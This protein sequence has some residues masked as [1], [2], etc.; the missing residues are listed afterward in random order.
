MNKKEL[1]KINELNQKYYKSIIA[2][3]PGHVYWKDEN[4]RFLGCNLN[5]AKD[6]GF[7]SCDD[8]VG[9]TDFDMPWAKDAEILQK[10]DAK[11]I[12]SK[13]AS[14]IEEVCELPD[15][16]KKIY[17]SHKLPL[18]DENNQ[19]SGVL[20]ISLDISDRKGI[21][22]KL[23]ASYQ[24]LSFIATA[25]NNVVR[26][27]IQSISL[28]IEMFKDNRIAADEA[29]EIIESATSNLLPT[30]SYASDYAALE[31]GRLEVYQSKI[32]LANLLS[33]LAEDIYNSH[34]IEVYFNFNQPNN[35]VITTDTEKLI[36]VL[37]TLVTININTNEDQKLIEIN[38]PK[39]KVSIQIKCNTDN[40]TKQIIEAVSKGSID[41]NAPTTETVLRLIYCKKLLN[42]LGIEFEFSDRKTETFLE[43]RIPSNETQTDA[44]LSKNITIIDH[45]SSRSKALAS[46]DPVHIHTKTSISS[47]NKNELEIT[48]FMDAGIAREALT[49]NK[50]LN[51]STSCYLL[52]QE[53]LDIFNTKISINTLAYPLTINKLIQLCEEPEVKKKILYVEDDKICQ[54]VTS[55]LLKELGYEVK[56]AGSAEAAQQYD[57]ASFDALLLD[58]G[59]PGITGLEFA[60]NVRKKLSPEKLKIIALTGHTPAIGQDDIDDSG[61]FEGYLKKPTSTEQLKRTLEEVLIN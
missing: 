57:L 8:I 52:K 56:S 25:I 58:M 26:T 42:I 28:A 1:L 61:L 40:I 37:Y 35:A 19:A 55:T 10:A 11:V 23:A 51:S 47:D 59:L 20:G 21:E 46:L 54:L 27:P 43:I 48:L 39:D 5:Q 33:E 3:L 32:D 16:T 12:E 6:A 45:N 38:T 60:S 30:L 13:R 29:I 2:V 14:V 53:G 44:L 24:Q 50:N 17:L 41:Y 4:G 22:N 49:K 36:Q 18:Y 34:Q 31:A 7:N 9:L 15:G